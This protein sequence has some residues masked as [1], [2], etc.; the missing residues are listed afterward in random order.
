[1]YLILCGGKHSPEIA[2]LKVQSDILSSLDGEGYCC[3]GLAAFDMADHAFIY[4]ICIQIMIKRWSGLGL[5]Y[6]ID[7]NE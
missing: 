2:L 1:M 3:P 7:Y 4:V 5:T 6:L